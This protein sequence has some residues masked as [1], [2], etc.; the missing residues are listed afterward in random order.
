MDAPT[1]P[2]RVRQLID[3]LLVK[4]GAAVDAATH[5]TLLI[6]NGTYCG[7]RLQKGVYSAVWF[8]EEDQ[9]KVFGPTGAL[10]EALKPSVLCRDAKQAA[11]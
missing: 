4:H 9:V 8:I 2:T 3:Q 7:H 10:L 6:H 11:A 1:Y 5:E